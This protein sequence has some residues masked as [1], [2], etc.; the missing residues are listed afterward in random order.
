MSR[1]FVCLC[2]G[3]L[4]G[5]QVLHADAE[6]KQT[7]QPPWEEPL[8]DI[9]T[10]K[11]NLRL[12][13]EYSDLEDTRNPGKALTLRERVSFTSRPI[14]DFKL[15]LQFQSVHNLLEDF[16]TPNGDGDDRYDVIADPE[17]ARLHQGYIDFTGIDDTLIR[18]GYQEIVLDDARFI[19]NV[20][21]RMNAQSFTGISAKN[22]SIQDLT[23]F[24]AVVNEVHDIFNNDDPDLNYL[25]L[26][27]VSYKVHDNL[28]A[29]AYGYFLDTEAD[30]RDSATYGLR[31]FGATDRFKYDLQ[32]ATQTDIEDGKN[33][34]GW[35]YA[36]EVMTRIGK[37]WIGG[38]FQRFTGGTEPGEAFDTLFSTAHKFNGWADQFLGTNGGGLKD[39]LQDLYVKG[40]CKAY[41]TTFTLAYHHFSA[42]ENFD[43]LYDSA[44]K[45][46]SFGFSGSYGQEIDF[47][48]VRKICDHL[49][50]RFRY[51]WYDKIGD[52]PLNPTKDEQVAWLR[53]E[54]AF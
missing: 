10:L 11:L 50:V 18:A 43:P 54:L 23:L 28:S 4:L 40:T 46:Y 45:T 34:N 22:T 27:N 32:A 52:D 41:E 30:K 7:W 49:T 29:T 44:S 25:A 47:D 2:A 13:F 16:R 21:W 17:G 12:G 6:N 5:L 37:G 38:G 24:L 31:L 39:G 20:G 14:G 36:G 33:H 48:A 19:G 51:A 42:T 3:W 15:F 8:Q 35:F 9:G 1:L 26:S 53:A